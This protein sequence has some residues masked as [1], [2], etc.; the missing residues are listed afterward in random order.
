[1]FKETREITQNIEN[2]NNELINKDIYVYNNRLYILENYSSNIKISLFE[3]NNGLLEKIQEYE[4]T[5]IDDK[6]LKIMVMNEE[7][8]FL[9]GKR[10]HILK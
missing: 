1:M 3:L 5:K 10:M 2:F 4:K 7:Q 9:F 8:I 6:N